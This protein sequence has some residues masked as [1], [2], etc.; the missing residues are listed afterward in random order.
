MGNGAFNRFDHIGPTAV[1]THGVLS[2]PY[3]LARHPSA[4]EDDGLR[5]SQPDQVASGTWAHAAVNPYRNGTPNPLIAALFETFFNPKVPLDGLFG[6]GGDSKFS[7]LPSPTSAPTPSP[8][9]TPTSF[10]HEL[11]ALLGQGRG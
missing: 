8:Q 2:D 3:F 4:I 6:G 10:L 9:G 5:P 1:V 11:A 7:P